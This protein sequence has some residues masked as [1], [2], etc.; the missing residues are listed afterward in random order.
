MMTMMTFAVPVLVSNTIAS[1]VA[2]GAGNH[3]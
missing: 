1:A 2:D 3:Y